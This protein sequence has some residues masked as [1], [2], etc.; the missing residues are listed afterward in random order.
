MAENNPF[1]LPTSSYKRDINVIKH[2]I[3][4]TARYVS[5][6]Y[7]CPI[8][9]ATDFVRKQIKPGGGGQFEFKDPK[10]ELLERQSN[11][12]RMLVE[13]PLSEYIGDS[14]K[15]G[16]LIA[17]TLTTYMSPKEK[18]SMLV[19]FID[20]N[21]KARSTAK[22]AYFA[23]KMAGNKG[24]E[25]IK[26]AEQTN[27]KLSNNSISGA[28]VSPST[29]LFNRT[30]HSTLTSN[31]RSTSGYGNANNEKFLCGNR[32]YWSPDIIR[33]NIISIINHTDYDALGLAMQ[34]FGIKHPS[35]EETFECIVY[36]SELYN[37]RP[38][39]LQSVLTLITKLTPIQRSAFV[40][41]G[42][43]YH[44][45]KHN[46]ALVTR[47]L[48]QLSKRVDSA[49]I[50]VQAFFKTC[51]E[52]HQHLA[53]QICTND[54]KGLT[55]VRHPDTGQYHVPDL[56]DPRVTRPES[57]KVMMMIA[58]TTQ[59][60]SKTIEEYAVMIRGLW[61]TDNVP[62]SVAVFP[63]SIRRAA[64]TSDTDSTIFTVQD[65]ITWHR[66]KLKFDDSA[67][68]LAATMI[69][70]A[71]Q[72][73]THV[74]ARMSANFGIEE[75]RLHQ[76]A[77]KNEYYFPA[78]VPTQV[79]KHYYALIGCQEGN[80]YAKYGVEIKGVH[81]KSSNAPKI[82]TKMAQAMM[83]KILE[84]VV[85]EKDIELMPLLR[86]IG[87]VELSV[88]D[89]IAHGSFEYF[90]KGQIKTPESY[91]KDKDTSPY[92]Q[93]TLWQEVF[94]PKYGDSQKP[95]YMAV[96]TS[97]MLDSPTKTREWI[98][99][100]KDRELADRLNDWLKRNN[101]KQM[102]KTFQLPEQCVVSRGIPE[103]IMDAI[104]VRAIMLDT[105]SVF[106]L[107]LETLGTYMLND[108]TTRLVSDFHWTEKP[109]E[110]P[111]AIAA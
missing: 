81:L 39:A 53:A 17:P 67:T 11:G 92:A 87:D 57:A 50:D 80:V 6:M 23:A 24:L 16:H 60:I 62:A 29:P 65:W 97:T 100:F 43:L 8:E 71:A 63:D 45:A 36:S 5:L 41:T 18:Q 48:E 44:L 109:T 70:L 64:I 66:G 82:V 19:D 56:D 83:V 31:C 33:N 13:M 94:A 69:F 99:S 37:V 73:I 2:Y 46:P 90:R 54:M 58:A 1:V 35:V 105:S 96:K 103:E 38:R 52:E 89:S 27:R 93:Y 28:H 10:V 25:A 76:I 30:G 21:V 42:D 110:Q 40:Y 61:V 111:L 75:K 7:G 77:M 95:P 108:K 98:A 55:I 106:Y 84:T 34:E 3:E 9:E 26:H 51:P 47:F 79:A 49:D 74:L 59:N 22:K 78:F 91:A 88:K 104:G 14:I 72:T 68:A 102:G 85:A 86:Q 12:D 101:K 15:K 107:V 4:D 32:H 20:T